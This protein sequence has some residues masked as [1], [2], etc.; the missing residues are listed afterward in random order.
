MMACIE[1]FRLKPLDVG[2]FVHREN[3]RRPCQEAE[4]EAVGRS[5]SV[6]DWASDSLHDLE[7]DDFVDN[8]VDFVGGFVDDFVGDDKTVVEEL[9][10]AAAGQD[11]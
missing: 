7:G 3:L 10:I 11:G 5:K 1:L 2:D 4:E 6:V 9:A 8:F